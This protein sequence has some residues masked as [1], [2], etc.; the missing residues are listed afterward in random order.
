VKPAQSG[1]A[2][3][4]RVAARLLAGPAA[5]PAGVQSGELADLVIGEAVDD[6]GCRSRRSRRVSGSVV[7]RRSA[8]RHHRRAGRLPAGQGVLRLPRPVPP[9]RLLALDRRHQTPPRAAGAA[10]RGGGP[11]AG[12]R[13]QTTPEARAIAI[14]AAAVDDRAC[15]VARRRRRKLIGGQAAVGGACQLTGT[16]DRSRP[17]VGYGSPRSAPHSAPADQVGPRSGQQGG[18]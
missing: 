12:G 13:S 1:R 3:Q 2:C 4:L 7:A 15:G 9:H 11:T 14:R 5:H 16:C 17:G 6:R 18:E 10:H 8:S